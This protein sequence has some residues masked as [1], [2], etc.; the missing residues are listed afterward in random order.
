MTS[1]LPIIVLGTGGHAKVVIDAMRAINMPII[2]ATDLAPDTHGTS[3]LGIPVLG[4]DDIIFEHGNKSVA[5]VNGVGSTTVSD[6]RQIIHRRF[7]D[8]GYFFRSVVHP[9][10]TIGREITILDGAQVMAGVVIQPGCQVGANTIINTRASVD[11][12]CTIGAHTHIGPG[13]VLGGGITVGEGCHIGAGATVIQYINIGP[14]ALIAAGA[15]VVSD[16]P[17]DGRVAGVPARNM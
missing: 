7:L 3:I 17:A 5:L 11:H 2:G 13:A 10:A 15:T 9:S 1:S 4:N 12:D 6:Q 8:A 14:G 16:I